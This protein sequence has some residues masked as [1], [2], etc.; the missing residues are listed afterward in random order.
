MDRAWDV[1]SEDEK[2]QVL[3]EFPSEADIIDA[4]TDRARPNIASLRNNDN[5]RHDISRY[6][7]NLREG[8]HDPEW[9][10]QAQ[11]A[12]RKRAL[13]F[14]DEFLASKFE[15]DWGMPMPDVGAHGTEHDGSC[16]GRL[17]SAKP[18]ESSMPEGNV[19]VPDRSDFQL[20]PPP[21]T[22]CSQH[23]MSNHQAAGAHDQ[24]DQ[25]M[26]E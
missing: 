2:K 17:S 3:A 9:I 14:Y 18:S 5:F 7:E 6:Q 13:G 15:E 1:L 11:A 12:H 19:T 16:S 23:D 10:S 20:P 4:G 21:A 26:A 22:E 25:A 24:S 8:R